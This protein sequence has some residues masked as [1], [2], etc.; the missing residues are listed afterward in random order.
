MDWFFDLYHLMRS[1]GGG[2]GG[3]GGGNTDDA[4]LR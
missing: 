3:G 4:E 2:G 1:F